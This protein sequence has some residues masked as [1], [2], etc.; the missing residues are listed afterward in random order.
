MGLV[1]QNA[2]F[3]KQ[4]FGRELLHERQRLDRLGLLKSGVYRLTFLHGA[5]HVCDTGEILGIFGDRVVCH[6]YL[7]SQSLN[8]LTAG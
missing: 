1:P 8:G 3:Q 5:D 7:A 6:I 4:G 2:E